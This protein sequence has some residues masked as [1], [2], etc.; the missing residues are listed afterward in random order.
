MSLIWKN[1][2]WKLYQQYAHFSEVESFE[3]EIAKTLTSVDKV[4]TIGDFNYLRR[5]DNFVIR[6]RTILAR[7]PTEIEEPPKETHKHRR[8]EV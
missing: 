2:M 3:P 1:R 5:A 7:S 6:I 4:T 8:K